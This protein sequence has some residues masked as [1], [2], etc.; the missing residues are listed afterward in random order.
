MRITFALISR[1]LPLVLLSLSERAS[2]CA[3]A[4]AASPSL[5]LRSCWDQMPC[6]GPFCAR[7][8]AGQNDDE[9]RS[10]DGGGE[11]ITMEVLLCPPE[12]TASCRRPFSGRPC[13]RQSADPRQFDLGNLTVT[14]HKA[15]RRA[16]L[17][18]PAHRHHE[19]VIVMYPAPTSRRGAHPS[20]VCAALL[21]LDRGVLVERLGW[22][23]G[24]PIA[25][26][27][28]SR[29]PRCGRPAQAVENKPSAQSRMN[30]F[31]APSASP[32]A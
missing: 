32:C 24:L 6:W 10:R 23:A 26:I 11:K 17:T 3:S 5:S 18:S 8:R 25:D 2:L 31:L 30:C 4:S 16:Q 13:G 20:R 19:V 29:A 15:S 28:R 21:V 7:I 1:Q 12:A 14:S 9:C 27:Q 22:S